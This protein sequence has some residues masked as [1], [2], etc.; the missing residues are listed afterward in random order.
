MLAAAVV[1]GLRP[2]FKVEVARNIADATLA[3]TA[4]NYELAMLDV[5]LPD[6]SGFD[7]LK[8]LRR[9]GA[10]IPIIM[11]TARADVADRLTGL[12]GGADDYLTKPF[13]LDE[14]I[15]RCDA[16][17]RR[18]NGR[19]AP[20]INHA[21]LC[22]DPAAQTVTRDDVPL[23][24]SAR[25]LALFDILITNIG[26]IIGKRQIEEQLYGWDEMIESNAVEVHVSHLRRKIGRE[27]IQT[28]RGLGYII[29]K[30]R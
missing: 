23:A 17:L 13:D 4:G 28:V 30:K 20:C 8:T 18:L 19:A 26:R 25:E 14:L 21:G 11:L 6:G 22:Y 3:L 5:S 9:T 24:L 29:P 12:N 16:L 15:A 10:T 27:T 1:D 7:L 2:R